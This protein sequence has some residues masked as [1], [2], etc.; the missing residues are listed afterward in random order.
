LCFRIW[1]PR[2]KYLASSSTRDPRLFP[3]AEPTIHAL[4]DGVAH[5]RARS[6]SWGLCVCT[7]TFPWLGFK[8]PIL[9]ATSSTSFKLAGGYVRVILCHC[10]ECTASS[11]RSPNCRCPDRYRRHLCPHWPRGRPPASHGED[12]ASQLS[13]S[14]GCEDFPALLTGK[15]RGNRSQ[16]VLRSRALGAGQRSRRRVHAWVG[17]ASEKSRT[18][19]HL[20]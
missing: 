15:R 2:Y 12:H 17:G 4:D 9:S 18:W 19:I 1:S 5:M 8:R 6:T 14:T 7:N 10:P 16:A 13:A 3:D 20:A 11:F